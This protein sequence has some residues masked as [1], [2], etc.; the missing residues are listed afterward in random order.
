MKARDLS[1]LDTRKGAEAGYELELV[2][3]GNGEKLG[4]FITVY[5]ADSDRY[6]EKAKNIARK[7]MHELQRRGRAPTR[8]EIDQ[9]NIDLLVTAT[10]AWRTVSQDPEDPG[11]EPV[12]VVNGEALPCTPVHARTVYETYPW[13]REQLEGAIAERANFLPDSA[14]S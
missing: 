6:Q 5:G 11:E 10:K 3:P 8:E 9:G 14:R 12:L 4:I 1:E 13:M 7:R 2:N